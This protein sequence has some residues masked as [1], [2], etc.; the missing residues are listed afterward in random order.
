MAQ[1][2]QATKDGESVRARNLAVKANLLSDEL[3]KQK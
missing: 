3:V 1:S 2:R